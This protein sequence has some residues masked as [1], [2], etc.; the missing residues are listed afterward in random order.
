MK[1]ENRG[2][3]S[4]TKRIQG[5]VEAPQEGEGTLGDISLFYEL[6]APSTG[7]I[8]ANDIITMRDEYSTPKPTKAFID[9]VQ[10]IVDRYNT[11]EWKTTAKEESD[12]FIF[13][14]ATS[15]AAQL[16]GA[17]DY[18]QKKPDISG[19]TATGIED[20]YHEGTLLY[21]MYPPPEEHRKDRLEHFPN[22]GF[23]MA[24]AIDAYLDHATPEEREAFMNLAKERR[25]GNEL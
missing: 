21:A 14:K 19:K 11:G 25:H 9:L 16:S 15:R 22:E 4:L 5:A 18:I 20:I 2:I 13:K 24:Q 10:S 12:A 23:I 7:E 17:I 6:M 3:F 1:D 8:I